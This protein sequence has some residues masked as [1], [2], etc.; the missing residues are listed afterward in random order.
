MQIKLSYNAIDALKN[1][2]SKRKDG[3]D[4]VRIT[5]SGYGC[6]GPRLELKLDFE[7]ENDIVI[8]NNGIIFL[9]GE[10]LQMY[11]DYEIDYH[12]S[13]LRKGFDVSIMGFGSG[14]YTC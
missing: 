10:E 6:S 12:H 3:P 9:V 2:I 7:K 11:E 14:N 4:K 1:E 13:L 5:M 8:E